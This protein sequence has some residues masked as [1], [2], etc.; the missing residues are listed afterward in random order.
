MEHWDWLRAACLLLALAVI[1]NVN[2]TFQPGDDAVGNLLLAEHLG[3]GRGFAM[4][5]AWLRDRLCEKATDPSCPGNLGKSIYLVETVTPGTFTNTF[6]IG[7]GLLAYAL[8]RP[9]AALVDTRTHPLRARFLVGKVLASCIVAASA[10]LLFL[11]LRAYL[12]AWRALVLT[13][14]YALATPNWSVL[15]Q[16]YLQQT[17]AL[18]WVTLAIP[19]FVFAIRSE[20][21]VPYLACGL[22]LG[23]ATMTRSTHLFLIIACGMYI[24]L[25]HR[26]HTLPFA[27]AAAL[28]LAAQ[29][30]INEALFGAA[31]TSSQMIKSHQLAFDLF[32]FPSPWATP[33]VDGI[34]GLL[35]SPGRG[36][37]VYSPV[38]V[39][40][41]LL[42]WA[43]YRRAL[44]APFLPLLASIPGYLLV[45]AMWFDWWGG[46]TYG[47]RLLV[48]ALPMLVLALVPLARL[49]FPPAAK[50]GVALLVSVSL[51]IH[52][53]GAFV[54]NMHWDATRL[55]LPT[56]PMA[57][58]RELWLRHEASI[59]DW[60]DSPIMYYLQ[61][62]STERRR[63]HTNGLVY[64]LRCT[65]RCRLH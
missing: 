29:L 41:L 35:F 9:V 1:Y 46:Y 21:T 22:A 4:D 50:G 48:D 28:P 23:I 31:L 47:Y 18:F 2:T 65:P 39:L 6:G 42:L 64:E 24:L 54:Y 15:S 36:L 40:L 44:P 13:L 32:A 26:R 56:Q 58:R 8:Y 45:G 51:A 16:A 53:L 43:P 30:F 61:N 12:P 17:A 34:T 52:G 20:R 19:L 63:N 3:E 49:K 25:R 27:L 14:V 57:E 38:F 33:V 59:R 7:P 55:T 10:A 62:F 5:Q 37:L 11:L 60:S